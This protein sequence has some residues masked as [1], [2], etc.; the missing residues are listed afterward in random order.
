VSDDLVTWL[1]AQLD[2]DEK[3]IA[4]VAEM[5]LDMLLPAAIIDRSGATVWWSDDVDVAIHR[6]LEPTRL[7]AE[8]AAKRAII[9]A[10]EE[11]AEH[12]AIHLK[13]SGAV[14]YG[15]YTAIE[16]LAQSYADQPGFRDE[17]RVTE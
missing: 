17:W 10:W 4:Y 16:S 7:F 14:A 1:R 13:E 8:V 15:L 3:A 2:E 11:E 9:N 6:T 12:L 5:G